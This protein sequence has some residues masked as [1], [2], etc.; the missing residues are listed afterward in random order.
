MLTK[1]EILEMIQKGSLGFKPE[2]DTFQIQAHA[3]DLRLGF[4]FLVAR[5]WELNKQGR[6]A[7]DPNSTSTPVSF[8]T[9]ELEPGQVFDILPNESVLVSTLENI[10]MPNNLVGLMYP[11]S[12]VNR[13]GLAVDLSGIIDAGYEGSLII[14]VRNNNISNVIRLYPGER[15][16]QLIFES[17]H[18]P[19]EIRESRYHNRDIAS[20]ILPEQDPDEVELV[21]KGHITHLKER[22]GIKNTDG[23]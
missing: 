15:F 16:C 10:K 7:L 17:L 18:G 13:R 11:R 23:K 8:N 6:V 1:L 9:I 19:A 22:Y 2:L 21:R 14:P 3:V 5:H 4:T 20:G 12:S